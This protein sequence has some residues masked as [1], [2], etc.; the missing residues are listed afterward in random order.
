[1]DQQPARQLINPAKLSL[2]GFLI[3]CCLSLIAQAEITQAE[4]TRAEITRAKITQANISQVE[5]NQAANLVATQ[6]VLVPN[7]NSTYLIE[8]YGT[9]VGEMHN[10][11]N[12]EKAVINYTATATAKGVARFFVNAQP[13]ETSM[14]NWPVNNPGTAPQL[15]SYVYFIEKKH[16][17]NQQIRLSYNDK[18]VAQ[19]EGHYKNKAYT[20]ES[21]QPVWSRQFLPLL[22][23][24]D[25][26]QNPNIR[27]NSFSVIN[28]GLIQKYTYTLEAKE[29]LQYQNK[30]LPVLKFKITK[31]G[32]HRMSYAWL[33]R[34]HYYLPLKIEQYKNGDLNGRML[35]THL[36]LN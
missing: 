13:K 26:Q 19:I 8:K 16:K 31:K 29:T 10:A 15:Q 25:L 30:P 20:V 4:V 34:A 28:K 36:K 5:N 32:S 1:M 24:S 9:N 7:H 35:M 27:Q 12:Y 17:K 21:A 18:N 14:L 11:L 22:M 23:S 33:S 2:I 3:L 6:F